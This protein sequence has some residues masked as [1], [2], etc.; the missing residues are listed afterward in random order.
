MLT[1]QVLAQRAE[2]KHL[3][4]AGFLGAFEDQLGDGGGV[5]HRSGARRAAQAGDAPRGGGQGFAGDAALA[6]VAGLA[7][8]HG[9]VDQPGAGDQPARIDL[10]IDVQPLRRLAD[11]DQLG[12]IEVEIGDLVQAAGRIDDAGTED[13]SGHQFCSSAAR[14][15]S[16]WRSAV[17]PLMVMDSTAMR[18][19]M[20]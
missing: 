18:T 4:V 15:D 1:G 14:S 13:T 10:L 3:G 19:A 8:G 16:S 6:P 20:P 12:G 17:W 2:G 9:Q 7:Q 5:Q 11:G